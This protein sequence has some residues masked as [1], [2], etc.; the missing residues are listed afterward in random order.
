MSTLALDAARRAPPTAA[1]T[2]LGPARLI[3]FSSLGMPL[4]AVEVP[5]STY[6]PPLYASAFGFSL[7]TVGVIFLLARLWDAVIDPAIGLLSD[8]TRSRWGRRRPWIAVGA[9]IF[10]LGAVPVFLPPTWFGP[11]A[12]SA[13]LFVLYLGYSM[14]ATPLAAWMGE[15]SG[16]YHER[17]RI[18]TYGQALTC[19]ALLLALVLPSLLVTR[20]AGQ[21]RLELAAMGAMVFALLLI[22]LPLGIRALPEPP[23]P[24][25]AQDPVRVWHTLRLVFGEGMLLRV[26]ASNFAV[27]LAQGVRTALFVFFISFYMGHSAWAPGLFLLQYVFGIFAC[28]LWL[29]IG[30]RVGKE[31][32]AVAGE[33]TQV[34]INLALLALAPG[35]VALLLALTVA[36]GLAQGSG[37]LMLRSIVADVADYHRLRTGEDRIGL[38]FSVFSLSDK[39]GVALAI[40]VA[41][42]LAAWIGF[43][44]RGT[45]PAGVLEHLKWLFALGPALGH[46]ISAAVIHGFPIDERRHGDIRRQLAARDAAGLVSDASRDRWLAQA[47]RGRQG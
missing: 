27:R 34:A 28:P 42:P 20:L 21:P 45:N 11:L 38:F 24:A 22:T 40:G 30:R 47:D 14:M 12:L 4:A 1:P 18:T 23:P 26:L 25:G 3:A 15:L 41:L 5:L 6:V 7:G 32:A 37:N 36:Q 33:L 35:S 8:R 29:A 10:A 17:T 44:P 46:V 39:A 43:D 16:A 19:V 9:A 2:R 13:A 31:R